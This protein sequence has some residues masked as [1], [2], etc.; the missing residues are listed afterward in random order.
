VDWIRLNQMSQRVVTKSADFTETV[1]M[2]ELN[3]TYSRG[4]SVL[5]LFNVGSGTHPAPYPMGTG[6]SFPGGKLA[7]A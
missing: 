3:G 1:L 4:G 7:G 5:S 6:G 2:S